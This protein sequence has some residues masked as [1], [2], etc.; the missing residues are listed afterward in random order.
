LE[1]FNGKEKESALFGPVIV[2]PVQEKE[3]WWPEVSLHA[4]R[5]MPRLRR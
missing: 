3:Q 5:R 1:T 4:S 2:H